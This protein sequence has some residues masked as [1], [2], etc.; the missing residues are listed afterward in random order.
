MMG[1][2][3]LIQLR[4]LPV[5]CQRVLGQIIGSDTEEIHLFCQFLAHH[6]CCR[7]LD[8]DTLLRI[9]EFQLLCGQ[10]CLHF[11]HDLFDP[12]H[13]PQACDHRIHDCQIAVGTRTEQRT[14]LCFEDFRTG[15]AD[16]DRTI[17]QR[18]ILLFIHLEI[19][20]LLV[21]PDIQCTDDHP[22]SCHRLHCR[23]ID[24]ELFFLGRIPIF[25]QINKLTPEQPDSA[26]II[27]YYSCKIFNIS[28]ISIQH[29]LLSVQ[30]N[31]IFSF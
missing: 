26:G 11:F 31:I 2:V 16:P 6:N 8:H 27:L 10:F 12:F 15:Q 25:F 14:K 29:D 21:C 7:S 30:R 18:R 24:T 3:K 4:I 5:D 23:L 22:F 28:Y 19:L 20:T 13:F 9:A 17:P 1:I